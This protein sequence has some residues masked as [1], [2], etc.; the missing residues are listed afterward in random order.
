MSPATVPGP[1]SIPRTNTFA[2]ISYISYRKS[3]VFCCG[4]TLFASAALI[5]SIFANSRCYLLRLTQ[6]NE[7]FVGFPTQPKSIGLWCFEANNGVDYN[8]R[9]YNFDSKYEAARALGT[10]TMCFGWLI[11]LFYLFAGCVRF[12]PIAFRIIGFFCI[13]NTLFQGLV[14]LVKKSDVC[15]TGCGLDTGGRCAIAATVFW[16]IA[17]LSSCGAGKPPPQAREEEP[18]ENAEEDS[19][20]VENKEH[21]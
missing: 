12:P 5:L 20:D 21:T 9:S 8:L 1:V 3:G 7:L 10:T 13:C 4:P 14:F 2:R 16:F 6:S 17:G 18:I 19:Q 11:W 15:E